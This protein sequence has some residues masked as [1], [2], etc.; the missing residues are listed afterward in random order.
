ME[1]TK[2]FE[3]AD[4]LKDCKDRKMELEEARM[5]LAYLQGGVYGYGL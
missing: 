4:R 5:F 2:I 3:I 1:N